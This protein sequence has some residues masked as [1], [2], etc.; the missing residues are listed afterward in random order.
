MALFV[1]YGKPNCG[2]SHTAWLVYNL[3]RSAGRELN[4][5]PT[6]RP[7]PCYADIIQDMY[8]I[9]HSEPRVGL[10]DFLAIMEYNGKKVAIIS[11]GDLLHDRTNAITSFDDNIKW[12]LSNH[13]DHIVC[14]ARYNKRAGAVYSYIR[15]NLKHAVYMWYKKEY[16]KD[17]STQ[18]NDAKKIAGEV[19][20]DI[21]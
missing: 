10:Y 2:K 20:K 11:S 18:I 13:V 17:L 21:K 9:S 7:K 16:T 14:T 15:R 3:V 8:N 6:G 5:E 1:I 12:A 19:F 4:F